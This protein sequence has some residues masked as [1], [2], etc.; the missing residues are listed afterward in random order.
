MAV[1]CVK[2]LLD[3]LHELFR[4]GCEYAELSENQDNSLSLCGMID[5]HTN[6]D[7]Q[8]VDSCSYGAG[9]DDESDDDNCYEVQFTYDEIATIASALANMPSIYQK[10]ISD[11]SYDPREREAFQA[12][13]DKM[14]D[15]KLKIEQAFQNYK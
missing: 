12:M 13:S 8:R 10:A 15:L 9:N 4:Q 11:E 7:C 2:D 5:E 1:Y 3:R 6:M 14:L